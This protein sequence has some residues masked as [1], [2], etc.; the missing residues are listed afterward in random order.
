MKKLIGKLTLPKAAF[1]DCDEYKI[2]SPKLSAKSYDGVYYKYGWNTLR[3]N[4]L[5]W[6]VIDHERESHSTCDL[7]P[8]FRLRTSD[9]NSIKRG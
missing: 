2:Y 9:A 3:Q 8:V 4:W 1:W 7:R 6:W 5:G